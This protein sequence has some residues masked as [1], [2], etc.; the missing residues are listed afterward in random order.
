MRAIFAA[1]LLAL[2]V[3]SVA[4]AETYGRSVAGRPLEVQRTGEPAAPTRVLVVGSIHG[5]E[6]AG[7]AVVRQLRTRTPP[8]GVQLWLVERANPDGTRAGTRQNARG[9]DLNRN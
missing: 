9:V 1:M 3:P 2:A 4:G 7:H 5:N 6:P 8:A